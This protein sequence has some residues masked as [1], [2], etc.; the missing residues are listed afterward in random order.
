MLYINTQK[1]GHNKQ[2]ILI[3]LYTYRT[4]SLRS[5]SI[6]AICQV[7]HVGPQIHF[8]TRLLQASIGCCHGLPMCICGLLWHE[9]LPAAPACCIIQSYWHSLTP[10]QHTERPAVRHDSAV[11]A[12]QLPPLLQGRVFAPKRPGEGCCWL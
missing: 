2:Y 1:R 12:D 9:C 7:L 5:L 11:P 6:E 3:Y 4:N 10:R 8:T